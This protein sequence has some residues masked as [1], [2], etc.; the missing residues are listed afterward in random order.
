M[1]NLAQCQEKPEDTSDRLAKYL[2]ADLIS[3]A[4]V[5]AAFGGVTDMALWRWLRTPELGFPQPAYFGKR[6]YWSAGAIR[7]YRKQ[8]FGI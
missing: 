7:A 6:R 4:T 5:R 3:A 8:H 1:N 2:D